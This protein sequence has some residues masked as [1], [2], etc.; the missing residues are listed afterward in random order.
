MFYIVLKAKPLLS[1]GTGGWVS[2]MKVRVFI[3]SSHLQWGRQSTE[4]VTKR[5]V[6]K[7]HFHRK[8]TLDAIN[9]NELSASPLTPTPPPLTTPSYLPLNP[10]AVG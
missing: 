1:P 2:Q 6:T 7:A 5:T 4:L 9:T 8:R 10:Q 3:D